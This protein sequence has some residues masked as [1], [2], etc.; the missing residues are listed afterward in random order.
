MSMSL[1]VLSTYP[2]TQC[3][4]ATFSRSLVTALQWSATRKVGVVRVVDTV[5][6]APLPPVSSQWV[7]GSRDGFVAAA[8][9]LNRYDVAII[10]HEYGIYGGRDGEDVLQVLR[11][12]H[13]PVITVLHTV[14]VTPSAHQREILEEL[15]DLSAVVVPMTQTGRRRLIS[16]YSVD[17]AKIHVI[18]HGAVDNRSDGPE[19]D[20]DGPPRILTWGL[21][22]E[23]KGI[24]WAIEA[25]AQL[26]DVR[27]APLYSVVGQTHPR[28]LETKGERYRDSLVARAQQLGVS[29]VVEFDAR[30][31]ADDE[32]RRVVRQ[33][34]IVLLPY[35]SA[36]QVTSGVL[37]EAIAAG[38]PVVSTA[39][40]HAEELLST[41]AGLLVPRHDPSAI[42]HALRR[43][44]TEPGLAKTMADEAQRLAPALLWPAVVAQYRAIAADA[45]AAR[46]QRPATTLPSTELES[47]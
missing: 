29:D 6:D 17:P 14:L 35:D 8:A 33:S 39:F 4:L 26:R 42:A 28:V 21:L 32:L 10:Q 3:G 47:A 25:M 40:P 27:P 5:D 18:P 30:Y 36:E 22:G 13:V 38:K 24:E 7:R 19:L 1:G 9:A 15:V 45:L 2:P 34:D 44:L 41:G 20:N 16:H 43:V 46:S 11:R 37:I 31:L 12:L 23:G